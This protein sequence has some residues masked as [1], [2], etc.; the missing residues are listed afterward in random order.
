MKYLLI[1]I[2]VAFAQSGC[3]YDKHDLLN[4]AA[5]SCDTVAV[6]F[7]RT[8]QPILNA[9][10]TGCHT[11]VGSPNGVTLDSW[12]G[13]RGP[14]MNGKLIGTITHAPGFS[15]M[16]KNGLKLSD[17]NIQ[18]IRLWIAGGSLNN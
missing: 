17:C 5:L 18:K 10:C 14:A 16:P 3:Y 12:A 15:Q 13:A 1:L 6:S 2:I 7:S 9:N 8:I 4:P 11:G